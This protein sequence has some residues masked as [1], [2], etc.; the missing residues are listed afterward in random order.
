MTHTTE[1]TTD[2]GSAQQAVAR[3]AAIG[4]A[5]AVALGVYGN[6]HD[7]TGDTVTTF[8]FPNLLSMKAWFATVA[9]VLGL[10]QLTSALWMYGR[11]PRV[12][13]APS[14]LGAI[15]RW[16]GTVAFVFTLPVAYHC[17]WSLGFKSS[18][19]R[20]LVHSVLGCAFYGAFTTKMLV[21]RS[22][23]MPAWALPIAGGVLVAVLTGIWLVTSLWYFTN[24]GFPG[25]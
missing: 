13:S 15:H 9:A 19:T 25:V 18:D 12:G 6:V 10:G 3:A 11:L 5:V 2:H 7:G 22:E 20:V 23:R 1:I 17:L 24:V 16:L 4:A 21:L 14:Q 8:W